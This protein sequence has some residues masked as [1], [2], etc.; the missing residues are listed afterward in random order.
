VNISLYIRGEKIWNAHVRLL[1]SKLCKFCY[2]IKS[3]RDVTSPRVMRT[4]YV[5]YF[6]V[7]IGYGLIFWGG[8]LKRKRIFKLQKRDIQIISGV[9][10]Y[11]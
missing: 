5:A 9:L 10:I 7:Y 4:T 6:H 2:M 8:D 11:E 1:S 3:L